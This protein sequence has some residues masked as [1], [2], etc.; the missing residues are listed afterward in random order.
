MHSARTDHSATLLPTGEVLLAGGRNGWAPDSA[1]DPP[2][3]PLFAELFD[4]AAGL[5]TS[6][7]SMQTT[8][9]RG[10]A[11]VLADGSVLVLGGFGDWLPDTV[12][13]IAS[14]P[15]P[16][17]LAHVRARELALARRTTQ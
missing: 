7:D 9:V 4:P 1:D 8:R 5:F 2:W 11:V 15:P 6:S 13:R 3:D 14:Q 17:E 12:D 10:Q 16:D